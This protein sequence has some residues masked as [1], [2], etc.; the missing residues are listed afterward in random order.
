M[1]PDLRLPGRVEERRGCLGLAYLFPALSSAGAS[2][3]L[4]VARA[5]QN[6]PAAAVRT[7]HGEVQAALHR[8]G[9]RPKSCPQRAGICDGVIRADGVVMVCEIASLPR[10]LRAAYVDPLR[11]RRFSFQL[12]LCCVAS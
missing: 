1:I 10:F 8:D 2:L 9:K 5:E 6:Q 12:R 3:A 11:G 4:E 7:I